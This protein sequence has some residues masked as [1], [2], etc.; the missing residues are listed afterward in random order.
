MSD[1]MADKDLNSVCNKAQE[2]C[3]LPNFDSG[4]L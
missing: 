3:L 2:N 1:T 4:T